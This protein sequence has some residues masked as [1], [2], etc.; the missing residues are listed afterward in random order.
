MIKL[1][2]WSLIPFLLFPLTGCTSQSSVAE[3]ADV[4]SLSQ[5]PAPTSSTDAPA[6]SAGPATSEPS[7]TSPMK[8]TKFLPDDPQEL[9]YEALK[10][11]PKG[12]TFAIYKMG[13]SGDLTYVP[14]LVELLRFSWWNVDAD[15]RPAIFESL[16]RIAQENP[17]KIEP[18]YNAQDWDWWVAWVGRHPE[19]NPPGGFA[20]WKG[21][22]FATLVDPEMGAFLYDGVMS[23]IR[24]EE[25]VWGGVKKDGIPD[26]TNPPVISA[27]EAA[28]LDAGDR[29]FGI[30]INGEHRAYPHRILNPH[31]MANDVVGGVPIAL[32]Y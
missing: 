19:V 7:V 11:T 27:Q 31:E 26:L 14:V 32:A 6:T 24:L 13:A 20:G 15:I 10:L 16:D 28:Y 1:F 18:E 9:I 4:S 23:T 25:I 21:Q 29:V 17:E 30:S 3:P 8:R 2:W 5:H 22:I 12:E